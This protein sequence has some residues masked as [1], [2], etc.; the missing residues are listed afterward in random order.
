MKTAIA[1]LA[2]VL[3]A[4]ASAQ[5]VNEKISWLGGGGA[6][7]CE[8][9]LEVRVRN[10]SVLAFG[11]KVWVVGFVDGNLHT[12]PWYK[13]FSEKDIFDRVDF[14]CHEHPSNM[15]IQAALVATADLMKTQ[16]DRIDKKLNEQQG[17]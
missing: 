4:P 3:I 12:E 7:L 2:A 9:W 5:P 16:A 11:L 10:V 17:H 6:T 14:Y 15:L 1:L 8:K 13:D